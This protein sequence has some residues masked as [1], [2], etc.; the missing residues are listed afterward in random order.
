VSSQVAATG[1]VPIAPTFKGFRRNVDRTVSDAS[2][3][4]SKR[5]SKAMSRGGDVAGGL[6]GRG[7]SRG[8]QKSSSVSTA[9]K[10][11][12]REMSSAAQA[13]SKTRLK[14][15]DAAGKVRVAE[16]QLTEARSK[17]A[18]GSSQVVRAEER[19]ASA[20][21]AHTTI[22]TELGAETKRLT[23][24]QRV[25]ASAQAGVG[26]SSRVWT[27]I[28]K[29]LAPVRTQLIGATASLGAFYRTSAGLA[30]V[31]SAV[32][33]ISMAWTRASGVMTGLGP[34][35]LRPLAK[36]FTETARS[37][38]SWAKQTI[39]QM[40][41]VGRAV[42]AVGNAL[43]RT[44]TVL[45]G[46]ARAGQTAARG[47]MSA[48]GPVGGRIASTL[49]RGFQSAVSMAG[50]AAS[51]I[52][53]A[54]Q[55][56]LGG[57]VTA[58]VVGLLGSLK[59]G[60]DRLAS[61]ETATAKM[62]GFGLATETVDTVMAQV[63]DS[64]QGT[65]YT[66]GD[67]GNAAAAAVLAG[68]KPGEKLSGYMALLKNTA[69]AAGAPLSEIQSI[70]GKIVANVGGPVTTEL[71]QLTDRGIP[72]WTILADKMG[73]SV[74]EV[75]K[76]ASEG[77]ITSDVIVEHLGGAMS[78]MAEEVG[79][80]TTSALQRM[81]SSFSRFGEALMQESFPG[82]KAL[83][84]AVRAV[85]DAAI[86]LMGPIKQAFGLDE[87]GPAIE[88]I[89]GFTD[90][91]TAFTEMIKSG[92]SE[93]T[94]AIA[95]IVEKI[96]ELAP[97]LGIAAVAA[98]PLMGGFLSSLPLIGPMLAGLGP[99]LLGG[100]APLLAG[101]GLIAMLGMEP[102]AFA[103]VVMGIV[104]SVTSGFGS[105][106]SSISSLLQDLIPVMVENLTANAPILGEGFR[107]LLLGL[108]ASV[109]QIIPALV[110]AVVELVPAIVGA[111]V[112]ALPGIIQ[113]GI[114]LL[115]G[116]VQGLVSAIPQLVKA[117]V[118]AVPQLVSALVSALPLLMQ[119]ALELFLGI[120][121]GLVQA[122]PEIITAIV[123]AIPELVTALVSQIPALIEGALQLFLG[124]I[125]GLVQAIPQILTALIGAIP[126][127]VTALVGTIPQ[128]ITG[129]IQL[130]LGIVTGLVQATPEI[131][132]AVI[133]MIPQIIE[134]LIDAVP[135]LLQAGVDLVRGLVKGIIDSA[136]LVMDAIGDMI[137]GAIGWAKDLLGIKSPSRV[138]RQIGD[139]LTQGFAVGVLKSADKVK[140]ATSK[141]VSLVKNQFEKLDGQRAAAQK[142]LANLEAKRADEQYKASLR[143]AD[144]QA[145]LQ[146]K[147]SAAAR[148][149][150]ERDLV[151]Q[152]RIAREGSAA[153]QRRIR[154]ERASIAAIDKL[155]KTGSKSLIAQIKSQEKAI[156]AAAAAREKLATKLKAARESLAD[157]M[158]IRDDWAADVRS[159]INQLGAIGDRSSV[160]SMTDNLKSQIE[161]AKEFRTTIDRLVKQ[162]L[163][164][165]SV[166]ELTNAFAQDGSLTAVR[167]LAEGGS[168]AVKE[169]AKLRKELDKV[170]GG[171]G[172]STG[173]AL[174]QSG[175]DA[176]KGLVK[177]LESQAKA[178]E[179]AG[180]KLSDALVKSVKKALSIKSPSRRFRNE[181]GRMVPLGV[182]DGMEDPGI[183]RRL[184]AAA[185]NLVPIPDV[186][187]IP[188]AAALAAATQQQGVAPVR[189]VSVPIQI[190]MHDRDPRIVGK[191]IGRAVEEALV[192]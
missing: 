182:L 57:V 163:D 50:Q 139:F 28:G 95:Q 180:K 56:V 14:E 71:N 20:R 38:G 181:V 16:A 188:G 109:G 63:K 116:I 4:A 61:V 101:G 87:V 132:K 22:S 2:N 80:T 88:K 23:E 69:T 11:V 150:A 166:E 105:A 138:F 192:G 130:F 86:A 67:M 73:L 117:V 32:A 160:A 164:K 141:L 27:Q 99:G 25:L 170:G 173:S 62:R 115:L 120:V 15:A 21:R 144:L 131:L 89:N 82:V 142:R 119:G 190:D 118:G 48:L 133:G 165:G 100:L 31:R 157:A 54:F 26:R 171:I 90:R 29:D 77:E 12:Q 17:H 143:V 6:A 83:A 121:Q 162:G 46:L 36:R 39:T 186:S 137:G 44:G 106:V 184:D 52:G 108:T 148:A 35:V 59:G 125:T 122:I 47:I 7:F 112:S 176:A 155:T 135:Q 156:A 9:L 107:Q 65:I 53:R 94:T 66:V 97:V 8:F 114:A 33:G 145:R 24:A 30:P 174:Y 161:R 127:I 10:S 140:T 124:L 103:G 177:G 178:L 19:L 110:S 151:A 64:V 183:A 70:F 68:V 43:G 98:L 172:K 93:G 81:R 41:V 92:S 159:Q 74:T 185:R 154:E 42:S 75:K 152:Q 128:L 179:K 1:F 111:L 113:G 60:F 55:G 5:F 102:S 123:Q 129:A 85:M 191:Q 169:V 146:G 187:G 37:A 3:S 189:D 49:G 153:T 84:D 58:G 76:L 78:Q 158:Q 45:G 126:Q 168:S 134:A 147:M 51:S 13:V 175:V 72:A 96:R 136:P 79:G 34:V 40:P 167:A 91:V 104:S 18:A 149:K